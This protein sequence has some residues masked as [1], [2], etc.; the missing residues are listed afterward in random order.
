MGFKVL[1]TDIYNAFKNFFKGNKKSKDVVPSPTGPVVPEID[2][3]DVRAAY[4]INKFPM[5]PVLYSAQDGNPR[6]V[7]TFIFDRSFILSSIID[8]FGLKG[9]DDNDTML[10]CC[11]FVQKYIKY[12]GDAVSRGQEEYWQNPEDT[13][14][15]GTGDCIAEYEEIITKE[16]VKKASDIKVGDIVLSYDFQTNDYVFKPIINLWDKGIKKIKRVHFRNG[17]HIDIT[18]EHHM[19]MRTNQSGDSIYE[20]TELKNVDLSRWWK[21]K[22]PI[23]VKIPYIKSQPVWNKEIYIVIGHYLAEGWIDSNQYSIHSSGYELDDYIVPILEENNIPF[24][25]YDYGGVP[26]IRFLT[27]KFK[28]YLKP[29]KRNSFDITLTEEL[30]TLPEEYLEKLLYGMWLGD[31][32]KYQYPDKRGY[33][34]NKEWTYSTSSEQLASDIQRIGLH[35]GRTFH[36]WKQEHHGGVGN[37]PMWR[38]N[39]NTNSHFLKYHGYSGLSEVSINYIEDIGEHQTYDWEVKDT[40]NFFFKG[41]ICVLNCEDGAILTKSLTLCAGV[42]D[43]KVKVVAGMVEGGGHAYCTYVRDDNTQCIMDWCYW[44]INLPVNERI[45]MEEE[46]SYHEIW[47][48]FNNEFSYAEVKTMYSNGQANKM[49]DK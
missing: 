45:S 25:Y 36:I 35:L 32:T 34:N 42:P 29:L 39:Y 46:P 28:E 2:P 12:V 5:V 13:I 6:D 44:P 4:W 24:T 48:S 41:G 11:L 20:K 26:C 30:M 21:R 1:A 18:N 17:Q 7:R 9:K 3:E 31:G 22:V 10:K 37:E 40:H 49:L 23:A 14:A 43:W 33:A 38:I 15:R 16:G 47:F 8:R 27:S 19:L